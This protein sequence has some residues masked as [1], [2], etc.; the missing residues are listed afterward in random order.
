MSQLKDPKAFSKTLPLTFFFFSFVHLVCLFPPCPPS[1]PS[2]GRL[3][4][5]VL[6]SWHPCFYIS[7]DASFFVMLF[8]FNYL[9]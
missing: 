6:L 4:L 8:K 2:L 3:K 7:Q 5:T 1:L 9:S